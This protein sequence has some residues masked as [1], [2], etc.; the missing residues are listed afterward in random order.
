MMPRCSLIALVS[1]GAVGV[2][3]LVGPSRAEP[4]KPSPAVRAAPPADPDSD[5]DGLS[6]FQEVHKYRTDP[7][8][9][10]TAGKG[11]A[12]GGWDQRRQ[13]TYSIRSVMRL[14]PPY[15]KAT[16]SD[17]YQDVRVRA[18]TRDYIELEV[19]S[20]PLNTNAQAINPNPNWRTD[21]ATLKEYLDPGVTTNWD[22]DMRKALLRELKQSG[23][24]PDHL[25]DKQVVEQVSRW[26][27]SVSKYRTMFDTYFVHFPGGVPAV[28]PGL[29]AAFDR[30][31]GSPDWTPAQQ[32]EHELFG[33]GMFLHKTH[34]SCTSAA[35]YL[36]TVLRALGIPT[37]I[38]IAMP[39][40]DATD[41]EQLKMVEKNLTHHEVRDIILQGLM[42]LRHG[43]S[44]HTLVE[45]Y[46]GRR[47]RRLNYSNLGQN[48]LDANYMGLLV[49][50]HTFRDLS[51]A[52]LAATWG[53][54]YGLG[55]RDKLFPYGNP[56]RTLAVDDLFGKY[57]HLPN[58]PVKE[59]KHLTI[60]RAYWSKSKDAPALVRAHTT[61]DDQAGHLWVHGDEW[62]ADRNYQQYRRF[63]SR[64]DGNFVLRAKGHPDVKAHFAGPYVTAPADNVRE[65]EIVIPP[66]EYARMARRVAY[67]IHPVN[68]NGEYRWRVAAGVTVTRP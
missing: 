22:A 20:Y 41:P 15:D 24:D 34:G 59:H 31:K 56:Y 36:T 47:W 25:T 17:D 11:L 37:R 42:P 19:I 57:S 45:V 8:K 43:F 61:P 32:F 65:M 21:N 16:L 1:F 44:N 14:M 9:K 46:V 58:P 35:V 64:A 2:S 13:F 62:F 4:P 50:V 68:A 10:D 23:I 26:L 49:H 67:T 6:D 7:H 39:L 28:Y 66:E 29:E 27:F 51:E 38:I 12:D 60:T 33:K 63:L 53:R 54:R 52:N 30:E 18:E 5:G 48:I 3:G 55:R 40:V